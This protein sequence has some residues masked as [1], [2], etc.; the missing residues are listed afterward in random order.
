M[1][2]VT[3]TAGARVATVLGPIE[4]ARPPWGDPGPAAD[5]AGYLVEEYQLEG[6]TVAYRP[7]ADTLLGPDGHWTAVIEGEAGYRTRIL[8]VRPQD[9]THFNGTVLLNWQNVSGGAEPGAPRHG[10]TYRGYAWVGVSAQEIG[11]YGFPAGMGRRGGGG[12]GLPLVDHDPSRYGELHHPGDQGSFDIFSQAAQ[13]VG[14]QRG[15]GVD[16]MG[17]LPVRRVLATGGSQ[18]AMRLVAYINAVQPLSQAV[19]GFLISLWEGRAPAL[20]DGPVS[21]GGLRTTV[22]D[23]VAVPVMIVNSEFEALGTHAAGV[24]ITKM[25]RVWEV[26]GAPHGVA[27]SRG[28][29]AAQ[30][31]TPTGDGVGWITNSLSIAPVYE[32]A[33]RHAH[34]WLVDATAP[35]ALPRIEIV[36]GDRASVHRDPLGNALGGIRLPELAVPTAE[37]RGMSFGAGRAA[38]FGASRP[39]GDDL[40]RSLYPTRADFVGRWRQ[41]VDHLWESGAILAEDAPAMKARG[42]EIRLPV[43]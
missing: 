31:R 13:A 2:T 20:Q 22:R 37:Y 26:A 28:E 21:Y 38:L 11:L 36:T 35:P 29:P 19:D 39:F 8:V 5:A 41:A 1:A 43:A 18:S 17:G 14:P 15:T 32:S 12:R 4:G 3:A 7:K 25:I 6:T 10:E 42:E 24:A 16:P 27:R 40:L 33:I 34:R 9:P 30:A 23:D